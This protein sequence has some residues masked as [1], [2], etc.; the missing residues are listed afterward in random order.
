[1]VDVFRYCSKMRAFICL[2]IVFFYLYS[3]PFFFVPGYIGSRVLLGILGFFLFAL[4]HKKFILSYTILHRQTFTL[5][6]LIIFWSLFVLILNG[7]SDFAFVIYP[8]SVITIFFASYF[9]YIVLRKF[10]KYNFSFL[11]S[12]VL[13]AVSLQILLSLVMFLVPSV[14]SFLFSII[15]VPADELDVIEWNSGIR[16]IGFGSTFFGAGIINGFALILLLYKL[17]TFVFFTYVSYLKSFLL[18]FFILLGGVFMS[19]TSML[20]FF[21]GLLFLFGKN[22]TIW[23]RKSKYLMC[24]AITVFSIIY[25]F[26]IFSIEVDD[27]FEKLSSYAFEALYNYLDAGD[28]SSASTNR[29]LEMYQTY[30]NNLYTWILGD[31]LYSDPF[32]NGYYM[33]VDI[34]YSRL[35]FYFGIIGLALYLLFQ[36]FLLKNAIYSFPNASKLFVLL[37]FFLLILNFKGFADFSPYFLLFSFNNSHSKY[38]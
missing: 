19:R 15:S 26:F 32:G 28:A 18:L 22:V 31:G 10:G 5:L 21:V 12:L 23:G 6:I 4:K 33:Q 3:V 16:L 30:P 7:T 20:G 9:V 34:G 1:M 11:V 29:L 2:I 25:I 14:K 37:F 8:I 17:R 35:I 27:T 13:S 36:F 24:S 38:C